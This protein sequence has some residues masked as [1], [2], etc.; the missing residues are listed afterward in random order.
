MPGPTFG[1]LGPAAGADRAS[2]DALQLNRLR[3]LCEWCEARSPF[4]RRHWA[5]AG[6]AADQLSTMDDLRRIP[7]IT[8]ADLLADQ[9]QSPPFGDRLSVRPDSLARVYLSS[10]TSGVG[11]EVHALS[12]A[13]WAACSAP[14]AWQGER[15]GARPG[16][17]FAV[18]LPMGMQMGGPYLANAADRLGLRLY[19]LSPHSTQERVGYL[20]RFSPTIVQFTPAYGAR[21]QEECRAQGISTWPDPVRAI[22]VSA[23]AYTPRWAEAVGAFWR[24]PI[25]EYYGT[26]QAGM[27]HAVSCEYG[28]VA[29]DRGP[30]VLH[31]AD[32]YVICEVLDRES[33]QP[34]ADGDEGEI[35]VTSLFRYAS[36]V[37]RF[38]T[39]DRGTRRSGASC[40]CDVTWDGL[41]AG[42]IGRYDDMMKIKGQN[43]WP[44]AL[45]AV[46]DAA[47]PGA[48]YRGV[49]RVDETG[50]ERVQLRVEVADP[51]VLAAIAA[52]IRATTGV[53]VELEPVPVD[54]LDRFEFKSRRWQDTRR[55]DRDVI[56]YRA[57]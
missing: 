12:P 52:D 49:V 57:R 6:F 19:L 32:P 40:P 8:K 56:A 42:G 53:A 33:G 21:L 48:E 20:R 15:V 4:Y 13:E 30:G 44:S 24:A 51:T 55:A 26:T 7:T 2:L 41:S 39:D 47:L 10:G 36:P 27:G 28:A 9:A 29:A 54:S 25:L 45:H 43:V 5:Q 17:G 35:V 11:Q 22:F 31:N 3:T 18:T 37:V 16:E 34:V 23:E 46:I 14:L 50:R 1:S 38:R